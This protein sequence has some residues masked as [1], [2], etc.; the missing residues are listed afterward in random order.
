M[1][2][3]VMVYAIASREVMMEWVDSDYRESAQQA[4]LIFDGWR[5]MR[6]ASFLASISLWP[7]MSYGESDG[8]LRT[9]V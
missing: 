4:H 7:S 3:I 9:G 5:K 1:L 2:Q 8:V 6:E